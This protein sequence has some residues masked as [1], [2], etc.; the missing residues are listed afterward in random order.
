MTN[1]EF[2]LIIVNLI[3]DKCTQ[4]PMDDGY[5]PYLKLNLDNEETYGL[6]NQIMNLAKDIEALNRGET[7]N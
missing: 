3:K 7:W 1:K 4:T 6:F 2:A 5:M